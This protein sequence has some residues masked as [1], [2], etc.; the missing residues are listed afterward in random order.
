M[1]C[2]CLGEDFRPVMLDLV[3]EIERLRADAMTVA[4]RAYESGQR[5][6]VALREMGF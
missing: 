3:R 6:E 1:S 4:R 2:T 5:D